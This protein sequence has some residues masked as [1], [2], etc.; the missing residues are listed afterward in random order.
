MLKTLRLRW[1]TESSAWQRASALSLRY[2]K[3]ARA[4]L[5]LGCWAALNTLLNLR[6]PLPEAPGS[7]LLPSIDS[8]VLLA[9]F[10][11]VGLAATVGA[12]RFPR[13]ASLRIPT[14]VHV[15]LGLVLVVLR[16]FRVG[17]GIT[18]TFH[19]RP[20]NLFIDAPMLSDLGR[21]LYTTM[22][23]YQ[24]LLVMV[25]LLLVVPLLVALGYKCCSVA[26]RVL[27]DPFQIGVFASVVALF[28]VVSFVSP[29]ADA[30]HYTGAFTSSVVPRLRADYKAFTTAKVT[31]RRD[32][33]IA[34][35]KAKFKRSSGNLA[36]LGGANVLLIV[37]ESYG[38]TLLT[39]P[40]YAERMTKMLD[41]LSESFD[42]GGY[43]Y[44]S[45]LLDSP[46]NGGYSW[47]A[48][49]S[50]LTGVRITNQSYFDYVTSVEPKGLV[51]Y[52]RRAGYFTVSVEPATTRVS[53]EHDLFKFDSRIVNSN[54]GYQGPR[55]SWAPMPDQLVMDFVR[56][57]GGP[58]QKKP[59]FIK[60]AL[61]SSHGPWNI[62]PPLIDDWDTIG[63]GSI[64]NTLESVTF[65]TSWT[66]LTEA[67]GP[68]MRSIEY[69]MEV[70][71]RYLDQF[72]KDGSLVIILGDHQPTGQITDHTQDARVPIHIVSRNKR[73]VKKFLQRGYAPGMRPDLN[74]PAAGLETFPT[75][76]LYDFS[77]KKI[78]KSMAKP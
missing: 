67:H 13:L 15:L 6:A 19:S 61:V 39:N 49:A 43:H 22:P 10:A 48:H 29:A 59:L 37:V 11:A 25:G 77:G 3:A 5:L 68:Y 45:A 51:H 40:F 78:P 1:L 18:Q 33:H 2:P 8:T 21:L 12:R 69:S 66:N 32:Q 64:Y 16:V 71:R 46:T 58:K 28:A 75:D 52:F 76:L 30:Q 41:G 23:G 24:L 74:R 20:A 4:L 53:T 38:A 63:D 44:A 36:H 47:L 35:A 55:Y 42:A 50:L 65:P 31:R 54:F 7:Y 73:F 57:H 62:Q 26:A 72:V 14:L 17:D 70:I 34:R 27:R 9:V 56:R 60:Y